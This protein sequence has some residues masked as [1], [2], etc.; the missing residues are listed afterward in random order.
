MIFFLLLVFS[1]LKKLQLQNFTDIKSRE[2]TDLFA[3]NSL[4][5]P[6]LKPSRFAEMSNLLVKFEKK[7]NLTINIIHIFLLKLYLIRELF[8]FLYQ[9]TFNKLKSSSYANYVVVFSFFYLTHFFPFIFIF[10]AQMLNWVCVMI[11]V[12]CDS[13]KKRRKICFLSPLQREY[14][15]GSYSTLLNM[16][17]CK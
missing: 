14:S 11:D 6:H 8:L 4:M 5:W 15:I 17:L 12:L 1:I 2:K 7:R 10:C 13:V 3:I 9:Q 16:E